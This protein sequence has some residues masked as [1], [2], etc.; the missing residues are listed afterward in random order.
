MKKLFEPYQ[1]GPIALKNRIVMAPLTRSRAGEGEVP[2]DLHVEYYRQRASAGLIITEATQVSRQG[3]GYLFTPGIFTPAQVAGWRKVTDAIHAAGGKIVLQAWHVGRISHVSLQANQAQPISSTT[4]AA[5]NSKSFAYDESGKPAFVSPSAPRMATRADLEQVKADFRQAALN[6]QTAEFDG[7]EIH[8]ANGYLIEQFLNSVVNERKD[9]YGNQTPENRARLLLEIFD[10]MAEVLGPERI[11]V[12]L[13]PYSTFNDIKPDLNVEETYL[14][15]AR[16][17]AR[18]GA[19]YIHVVRSP[20]GEA[21][22][23]KLRQVFPGTIILTGGLDRPT[24]EQ[25]LE[26][27]VADLFGFGSLFISNPDLPERLRNRWQLTPPDP[28]T[29]YGGDGRGYI[30]Y[31]RYQ[32]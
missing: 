28:T 27:G 30:D 13:S 24:S 11:G 2:T 6:L 12:R 22:L 32:E 14:Y 25:L 10:T 9:E 16:E 20:E 4:K 3:Q 17:L 18:R 5:E 26:A 1:L 19:L 7:T 29:F 31:P 8:A 21:L 15:V 23:A